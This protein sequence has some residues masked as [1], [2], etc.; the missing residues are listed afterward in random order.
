M[1][2][3]EIFNDWIQPILIAVVLVLLIQKFL[4]FNVR[5]PSPSMYPTIK[6]GD[7]IVVTR[8]Y[9]KDTL[10]RG[11]ILV[12]YSNELKDTLIKRLIGLPG[13]VIKIDN[14]GQVFINEKKLD[15]PYVVNNDHLAGEFT[16]PENKYFFL[17]DNRVN[18]GDA[19]YWKEKYIDEKEIKG[20]AQFIFFPFKRFG[21]FVIG[22]AALDH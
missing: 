2:A 16:V 13:D 4:F 17:G 8:I 7:R 11:D 21:K 19:R 12:F 5:V 1:D 3:K 22:N 14:Q 10:K 6:V 15:E 9:N 18:S 20:K